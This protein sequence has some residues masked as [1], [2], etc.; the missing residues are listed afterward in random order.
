M[1]RYLWIALAFG[2]I[3]TIGYLLLPQENN[4]RIVTLPDGTKVEFLGTTVG[5]QVF[6]S[7]KSWHQL[8]RRFLPRKMQNWVPRAM[9]GICLSSS[10]TITVFLRVSA[11]AGARF[12]GTP[13]QHYGAEDNVGFRYNREGGYC[14]FG[15]PAGERMLGLTLRTFPRREPSFLFNFYD[16]EDAVM[17]SLTVPNPVKGPFEEWKPQPL[18]Q[19]ATNGPVILTLES[20]GDY[21][22]GRWQSIRPKWKLVATDRNW[23]QAKARYSTILDATGNQAQ[24]LSTREPAWKLQTVVHREHDDDFQPAERWLVNSIKVPAEGGFTP[25]DQETNILGVTI[26]AHLI[27]SPGKLTITNGVSRGHSPHRPGDGSHSSTSSGNIRTESWAA[28]RPFLL[29]E[30]RDAE[31]DDEIRIN[32]FDDL[33]EEIRLESNRDYS[34]SIGGGRKYDREFELPPGTESLSLEVIVSRPLR[35]EFMVNPKDIHTAKPSPKR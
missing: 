14:S 10:N 28:E 20:L 31:T 5:S 16:K 33:G 6:T 15:G 4:T 3:A 30:V 13:W 9:F 22:S 21:G 24:W 19:S 27:S 26:L 34:G 29:I 8:A 7:D 17:G 2:I 23:E 1:R 12:K 32:L 11:P 35:F 25:I 18:P